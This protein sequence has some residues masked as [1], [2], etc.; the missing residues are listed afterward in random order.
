MPT[1]C[2][3]VD[4]SRRLMAFSS[5]E[6]ALDILWR[7]S[8]LESV[9]SKVGK[10]RATA[11]AATTSDVR[12]HADADAGDSAKQDLRLH[13]PLQAAIVL[14]LSDF[15]IVL[16]ADGVRASF[17]EKCARHGKSQNERL[18]LAS[19]KRTSPGQKSKIFT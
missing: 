1:D 11:R 17:A 8:L 6:L 13:S 9:W 18:A 5:R 10:Q 3:W 12:L 19:V 15:L 14:L 4:V 7:V 2:L 16:V